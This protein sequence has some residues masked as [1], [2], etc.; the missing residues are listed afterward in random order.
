MILILMIATYHW[1]LTPIEFG[2]GFKLDRTLIAEEV[3]ALTA[4]I[5]KEYAEGK[6]EDKKP[7]ILITECPLRRCDWCCT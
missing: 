6:R 4:K 3:N 7:R 2:S 5:A 1:C